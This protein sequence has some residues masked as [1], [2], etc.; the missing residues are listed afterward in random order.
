[1]TM[2][3]QLGR[4]KALS[5]RLPPD[6]IIRFLRHVRLVVDDNGCPHW[7]W[8]RYK[9]GKGYGQFKYKGRAWWAHRLSYATFI[10]PIPDAMTVNHKEQCL[11]PGCVHPDCLE[12]L[13]VSE[14][15]T[16]ANVRRWTPISD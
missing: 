2:L 14:N 15:A 5:E 8:K 9:D 4:A 3:H 6:A 11:Q 13:T 7:I 10:G 1:M 16:D 12:L